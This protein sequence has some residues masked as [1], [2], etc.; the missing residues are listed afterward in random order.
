MRTL[1]V[2]VALSIS[3]ACGSSDPEIAD[4]APADGTSGDDVAAP[5]SSGDATA[6]CPPTAPA[7]GSPC[8]TEGQQCS[9]GGPDVDAANLADNPLTCTCGGGAWSCAGNA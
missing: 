6:A 4:P 1:L 3:F 5:D 2:V 9:W 7:H 8:S